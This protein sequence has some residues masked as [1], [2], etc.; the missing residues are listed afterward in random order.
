MQIRC[1]KLHQIAHAM[2]GPLSAA[3]AAATV[4]H[5]RL[6][7]CAHA[8]PQEKLWID[9]DA[10]VDDAQVNVCCCI[11]LYAHQGQAGWGMA[12]VL[13][14]LAPLHPPPRHPRAS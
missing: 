2:P 10:G 4:R 9:V 6:L 12:G 14:R 3:A 11:R 13:H 5:T 8:G 7:A 1:G